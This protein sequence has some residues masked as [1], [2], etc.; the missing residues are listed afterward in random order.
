MPLKSPVTDFASPKGA[1]VPPPVRLR[2]PL[3]KAAVS[4]VSAMLPL[5]SSRSQARVAGAAGVGQCG[6]CGAER[7]GPPQVDWCAGCV[8]LCDAGREDADVA[9]CSAPRNLMST[10]TL[11]LTCH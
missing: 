2:F 6:G 4:A 11:V 10:R 9:P 5:E 8:L 1:K 7:V 3:T